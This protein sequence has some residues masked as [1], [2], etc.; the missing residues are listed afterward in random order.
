MDA[1]GSALMQLSAKC[2]S[3][4][5]EDYIQDGLY[6]CHKC[7]TPKQVRVPINGVEYIMNK[8]CQ[9]RLEMFEAE[10]KAIERERTQKR[11]LS[12]FCGFNNMLNC[13]FENDD[14]KNVKLT[15]GLK[16][17]VENFDSF[18]AEGKGLLLYGPTETGKTH[19]AAQ[20]VNALMDKG[21][22]CYMTS[23]TRLTNELQKDWSYRNENLDGLCKYDLIVLDD[24]G[25]ERTSSY[26]QETAYLI[27]DTLNKARVPMIVTTNL[28][29]KE[30]TGADDIHFQ[31]I[32]SRVKEC[33]H[34]ILVD[35]VRRRTEKAKA[36]YQRTKDILGI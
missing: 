13:T 2:N 22:R 5:E 24:M 35:G 12:A 25:T 34:P 23:I 8:S 18:K 7:H 4:T 19:A 15:E 1:M 6:Y 36:D 17:Y 26:S 21:Y 30:M 20:V 11:K 10:E 28:T 31:R 9:C 14:G 29:A 32:Y 3:V 27:I 16:R 33:C